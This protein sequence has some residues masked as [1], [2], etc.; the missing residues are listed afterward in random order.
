MDGFTGQI[1]LTALD[2]LTRRANVTAENIANAGTPNYRPLRL[3]FE[4]ALAR[5]A[6]DGPQALA[7]FSPQV[8]RVQGRGPNAE[9]RLDLE[10]ATQSATG[11][12]YAA[13]IEVLGRQMQLRSLATTGS[14]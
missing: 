6:A 2:C 3:S 4:Q 1:L 8:E 13:M 7:R 5:A 12:R 9:L 10:L 11:L 14:I